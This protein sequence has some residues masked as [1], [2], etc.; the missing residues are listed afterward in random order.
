MNNNTV[1]QAFPGYEAEQERIVRQEQEHTRKT[2]EKAAKAKAQRMARD[3]KRAEKKSLPRFLMVRAGLLNQWLWALIIGGAL[4]GL[5]INE[6]KLGQPGLIF[7]LAD[8]ALWSLWCVALLWALYA[9]AGIHETLNDDIRNIRQEMHRYMHSRYYKID[10][11]DAIHSDKLARIL[12]QH[13]SKYNPGL[14]DKMMRNPGSVTDI[15]VAENIILGHL[16]SHPDAAQKILETFDIET[17]PHKVQRKV[18]RYAHNLRNY[19]SSQ[20]SR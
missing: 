19:M 11:T 13:I 18:N 6:E 12:V 8:A 5:K 15:N 16:K 1:K 20:K 9:T 7:A 14:F 4:G 3:K 10:L 17:M 2:M